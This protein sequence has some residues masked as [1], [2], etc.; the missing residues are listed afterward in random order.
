MTTLGGKAA[1]PLHNGLWRATN[2]GQV[3]QAVGYFGIKSFEHGD[4]RD[5]QCT[6]RKQFHL[7]V[8]LLGET[9]SRQIAQDDGN[10][11]RFGTLF[12][13]IDNARRRRGSASLST[14][15]EVQTCQCVQSYGHAGI[16]SSNL[17]R[18]S[19][20]LQCD[21]LSFDEASLIAKLFGRVQ[22]LLPQR[23]LG[24]G[25]LHQWEQARN[26]CH[27]YRFG[28]PSF[29]EASSS[30]VSP[31]HGASP[32]VVCR[33]SQGMGRIPQ[34]M[35]DHFRITCLS[36]GKSLRGKARRP[37]L[38]DPTLC[39]EHWLKALDTMAWAASFHRG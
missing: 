28:V 6:L 19:Q 27:E 25:C 17:L 26:K 37:A 22:V 5:L 13:Q 15:G 9:E 2:I 33:D 30:F 34:C 32:S 20:L 7:V 31:K 24:K 29:F 12:P 10:F 35:E 1:Q 38:R 3:V 21:L 11:P 18:L 14:S 39:S 4:L 16:F 8:L 36:Y 23:V